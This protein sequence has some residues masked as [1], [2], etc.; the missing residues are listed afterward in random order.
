MVLGI[1][2]PLGSTSAHFDGLRDGIDPRS[3]IETVAVT[4]TFPPGRSSPAAAFFELP[5]VI[6]PG[7]CD[8]NILGVTGAV[9]EKL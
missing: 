1:V 4:W 5:S 2:W 9:P 7:V 3:L 6:C 8:V